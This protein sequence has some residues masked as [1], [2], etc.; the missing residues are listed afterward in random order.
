MESPYF[1]SDALQEQVHLG[2]LVSQATGNQFKVERALT[3]GKGGNGRVFL[4][5]MSVRETKQRWP[6]ALKVMTNEKPQRVDR[7]RNEIRIMKL[8]GKHARIAELYDEGGTFT[9]KGRSWPWLA[10]DLGRENLRDW[11]QSKGPIPFKTGALAR[12]ASQI[13]EALAY[14]HEKDIVHRDIKHNNF[15]WVPSLHGTPSDILMIDFGIAKC[16][17]EDVSGMPFD[18]LTELREFVGPREGFTSPELIK[19]ANDRTKK[20]PVLH[21]SDLW[22]FG[23]LLWFLA[24]GEISTGIPDR[25]LDP[26]GG[27]LFDFVCQLVQDKESKRPG[28]AAAIAGRIAEILTPP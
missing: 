14:I 2:T 28:P 7:F 3:G 8:L 27:Q 20:Y 26:T 16:S 11:V 6:C 22:Q 15:V 24:T 21:A 19:Y 5:T 18:S 12:V 1:W 17:G 25:D 4:A 13:C 23:R 9:Y 10:M